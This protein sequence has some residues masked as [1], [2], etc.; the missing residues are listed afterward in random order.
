M[1]QYNKLVQFKQTYGD[2]LVPRGYKKDKSLSFWVKNQRKR[3]G[4]D[5]IRQDRKDLLDQLGFV[6]RTE[7]HDR[8]W[9]ETFEKLNAYKQNHGNCSVRR[10]N[11]TF[12][13]LK[14]YKQNHGNC[15]VPQ[16]F[17]DD[18]QLGSWVGA[19][20]K[21]YKNETLW[22]DRKG[23]LESIGFEWRLKAPTPTAKFKK[24]S[25]E[26]QE[27]RVMASSKEKHHQEQQTAEW[28][29]DKPKE[30]QCLSSPAQ[31]A[32]LSP[33][34]AFPLRN[35]A[36][37]IGEYSVIFESAG[38]SPLGLGLES[39]IMGNGCRVVSIQDGGQAW[40]SGDIQVGDVVSKINGQTL[41]H[42]RYDAITYLLH[43]E[44]RQEVTF[45]RAN[46]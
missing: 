34:K 46:S 27:N 25:I 41:R 21:S 29:V 2:C 30:R 24:T 44:L 31:E 43:R 38:V 4:N 42:F 40:Q 3:L 8:R 33:A 6:W 10:W 36:A 15:S 7:R 23:Q 5:I 22:A 20:R 1:T 35:I 32:L 28:D 16:R 26:L 14:A 45:C 12:E 11:E 18:P 39:I 19:Q 37:G 17:Q 9:N 13:K